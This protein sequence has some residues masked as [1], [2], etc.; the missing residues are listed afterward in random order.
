MARS[1]DWALV[2][3]R[4]LKRLRLGLSL[5]HLPARPLQRILDEHSL[6]IFRLRSYTARMKTESSSSRW[7]I[8]L[9]APNTGIREYK[10]ANKLLEPTCETHA[11]Q[12]SR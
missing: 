6:K 4:L 8:T 7:R 11:A 10:S 5:S 3:L 1:P 12:Q 9:A 2:S